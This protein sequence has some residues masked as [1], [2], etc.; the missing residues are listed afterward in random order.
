MA[1]RNSKNCKRAGSKHNLCM[2]LEKL[3]KQWVRPGAEYMMSISK[4]RQIIT[5]RL[6]MND[7]AKRVLTQFWELATVIP[8][9]RKHFKH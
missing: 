8:C 4:L 6:T 3:G 1:E 2:I 9:A 5:L 7:T